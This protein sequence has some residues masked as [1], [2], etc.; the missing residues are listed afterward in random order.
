MIRLELKRECELSEN[1][2]VMNARWKFAPQTRN[3]LALSTSNRDWQRRRYHQLCGSAL[4]ILLSSALPGARSWQVSGW[5]NQMAYRLS[6]GCWCREWPLGGSHF[7]RLLLMWRRQR[8][9]LRQVEKAAS[10]SACDE[11]YR[12]V[13]VDGRPR[14]RASTL[15]SCPPRS[16]GKTGPSGGYGSRAPPI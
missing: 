6:R 3:A 9:K 14:L 1:M 8:A 11:R 10:G 5:P 7:R 15:L 12:L 4:S 13:G 16:V 2:M